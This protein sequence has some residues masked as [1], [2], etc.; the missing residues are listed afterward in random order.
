M[1]FRQTTVADLAV[2]EKT[3]TID[4]ILLVWDINRW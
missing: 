4:Y 3:G 2:L 1:D